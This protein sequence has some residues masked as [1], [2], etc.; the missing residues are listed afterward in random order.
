MSGWGGDA[1]EGRRWREEEGEGARE[2]W[3]GGRT[4]NGQS[5]ESQRSLLLP[6]SAEDCFLHCFASSMPL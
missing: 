1:R 2:S 5:K 6:S 4:R 3:A